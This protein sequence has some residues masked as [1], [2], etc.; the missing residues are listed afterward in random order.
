MFVCAR[1]DA[2]LSIHAHIKGLGFED[3]PD[4]AHLRA[5]LA[6]LPDE[7]VQLQ[8]AHLIPAAAQAPGDANGLLLQQQAWDNSPLLYGQQQ[9]G[10]LP[11]SPFLDGLSPMDSLGLPVTGGGCVGA[12]VCVGRAAATGSAGVRGSCLACLQGVCLCWQASCSLAAAAWVCQGCR[13]VSCM[14]VVCVGCCW[15]LG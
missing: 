15:M 9:H 8:L 1:A 11:P 13:V 3:T 10:S 5:C 14:Y 2:L 4:Y 6:Q 7:Q 12:C